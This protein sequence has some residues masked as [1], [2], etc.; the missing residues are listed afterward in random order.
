MRF[1]PSL[2][3]LSLFGACSQAEPPEAEAEA[4]GGNR[5]NILFL[6]IDD[7]RPELGCYGAPDALSPALDGLAASG[8]LFE[9]AYCQSAVCN[10][11]RA[12]LMTG[13]RP[14]TIGV[15]D[16]RTD[17]RE[18]SPDVLTLPQHFRQ[19]GYYAASIGKIYHNIFPDEPS[20]DERTYL[21][22]FPFDP[23]AVY[24]GAEGISQQQEKIA[25]RLEAGRPFRKD[26]LG[27]I[28]V[29][30]QATEAP[31]VPD[32]AYY[33]GAQTDWAVA[34]LRELASSEQPWFLAV[35]YYRPHL[36]FNAPK[37]Y[38]DL[39]D[40]DAIQIAKDPAIPVDAPSMAMNNLRELRGYTDFTQLGHP[41]EARI[42]ENEQRRLKHGY[43][44]S[45][46]YVDAQISRLLGALEDLDLAEDTI[47]VVWG[48][49]GW[50][51]GEKHSWGKMTN[52]EID[53]R[54]PLIV[55]VP[56]THAP[57]GRTTALVEF[58]DI[59]PTLCELAGLP[60]PADL[61]GLSFAPLLDDPDRA[62]KTAAFSQY[63]RSGIWV[64]PSGGSFHGRTI[65]TESFR[66]VEWR[67]LE[68]DELAGVEL[69]DYAPGPGESRNLADDPAY[70]E[71]R[72]Q[73][74]AAL[75][76]GWRG[77]LPSPSD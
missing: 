71:T 76:D 50:K 11:S 77:A 3:I 70:A 8:F 38:W 16:L 25:A 31:D 63:L 20:W 43:L 39:Y 15:L 23:D 53:T 6:A 59:F 13:K 69:Y 17:L 73:L 74:A 34:K 61:E 57:G 19:H 72:E 65:R 14:E 24:A 60:V 22:G 66:Y 4:K 33:D 75:Q 40:R 54:V 2:L 68:S 42:S 29:K 37:R 10:P 5:P 46:S 1:A 55:R 18:V 35:G 48:D 36:P 28:Y 41:T 64:G 9:R 12:S 27:E 62:W 44:A 7:L 30:A 26:R 52:F 58:V 51:L 21:P 47:V 32:S 49:H 67:T 45:V 56:G